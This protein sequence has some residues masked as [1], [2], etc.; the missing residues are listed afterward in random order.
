MAQFIAFDPYAEVSGASIL[1]V[2]HTLGEEAI[3]PLLEK[4]G[5]TDVTPESWHPQQAWLDVLRELATGDFSAVQDLVHIGITTPEN[6]PWPPEI[7]TVEDALRSINTAY[8]MNHRG[9]VGYYQA[10]TLDDGL[11][12]MICE[13]PYPCDFDYG[14]IYGVARAYLPPG[15]H[16]VVE[17]DPEGPCRKRG[18]DACVYYVQW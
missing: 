3:L 18:D 5:I 8:H 14:L 16:L 12:R 9:E 2:V 15:T 1:S 6:A 17:H 7:Q 11:I 4:H 10:E 13:N